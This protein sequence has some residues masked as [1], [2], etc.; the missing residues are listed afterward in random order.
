MTAAFSITVITTASH[1]SHMTNQMRQSSSRINSPFLRLNT[2]DMYVHYQR[3]NAT[4]TDAGYV[5]EPT[6]CNQ[7]DS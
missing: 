2:S 3:R 4:Y 5:R 6:Q 7:R 1:K